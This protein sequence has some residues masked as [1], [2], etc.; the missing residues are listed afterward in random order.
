M[1]LLPT[2]ELGCPGR[3]DPQL[4][5]RDVART[6][7]PAIDEARLV[8]VQGDTSTAL[9]GALGAAQAGIPV[10]HVEAGLRSHD[11]L[12]PWPEEDF[13]IAIDALAALLFAPT[14]L[15]AANLRLEDVSGQIEVTGN[16]GIDAL[17]ERLPLLR[18][19]NERSGQQRVLVTCH[20]RESWG[21]GFEAIA[22]CL[23]ELARRNDVW[24]SFVLHPNPRVADDM[25]RLLGGVPN[26]ELRDPF[27]HMKMLQA[28][29]DSDLVLSDSGGMQEEAPT[30]GVP[31]LILRDRTERPEGI[32]TGNLKLVG[33][34][35]E[36]V[37]EAVDALLDNPAALQSMSR[38]SFPYGDGRASQRIAASIE[39]W[40]RR[41]EPRSPSYPS[42]T[43]PAERWKRFASR[44]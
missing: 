10:A 16:T 13:R 34:D 44:R 42:A 5:V 40:L 30:L 21:E 25:R 17:I 28:M 22:S 15:S 24:I 2:V 8:V 9:G 41:D 32:S 20:R 39:A 6:I 12:N 27:A 36:R 18:T 37:R 14:E 29:R 35:P 7:G 3:P 11:R 4:H 31:L 38:P 43:G 19:R 26:I 33:R 1:P 23:R